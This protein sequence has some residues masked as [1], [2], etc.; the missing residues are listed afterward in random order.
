MRAWGMAAAVPVGGVVFLNVFADEVHSIGL[1]MD[2]INT[3][4]GYIILMDQVMI[5]E[6]QREAI[7][8]ASALALQAVWGVITCVAAVG[9]LSSAFL[10]RRPRQS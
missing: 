7:Q 8:D 6:G 9:G 10:W 5:T 3:A 2:L 4:R 1:S